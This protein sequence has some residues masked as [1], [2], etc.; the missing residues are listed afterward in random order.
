MNL[1]LQPWRP[2]N[3]PPLQP[4]Q[5]C[6]LLVDDEPAILD[7][8]ANLLQWDFPLLTASGGAAALEQ[9]RT[10]NATIDLI[11]TD[12]R[13]PGMTGIEFLSQAAPLVPQAL[14]MV[15][16]GYTDLNDIIRFINEGGIY[17]Y[18]TKPFDPVAFQVTVKRAMQTAALQR[19]NRNLLAELE[20]A[21]RQLQQKLH[22]QEQSQFRKLHCDAM[23]TALLVWELSTGRGKADLADA[24]G[25]WSTYLDDK[26]TLRA[27]TL[28]R[29]LDLAS[30]PQ[31]PKS[32]LVINTLQYVLSHCQANEQ[33]R[34][35]LEDHLQ[36][37]Q[38]LS[39]QR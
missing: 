12:Q 29:Y 21:N 1:K 20:Q 24:S 38:K 2:Q 32:H 26:G 39:L 14:R 9:I 34:L 19:Q 7:S 5:P 28:D 8:V 30:L 16:T 22:N 35:L 13:M 27:K 25:H 18:I 23:K 10:T 31:K 3:P 17:K 37:L 36:E 11:I 6:I 4:N 15:I 33:L